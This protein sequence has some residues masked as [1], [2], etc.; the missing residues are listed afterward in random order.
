MSLAYPKCTVNKYNR[1]VGTWWA[2]YDSAQLFAGNTSDGAEDYTIYLK[3]DL[4][5]YTPYTLNSLILHLY[6]YNDGQSVGKTWSVAIGSALNG[7][8]VTLVS[9]TTTTF[10]FSSYNAWKDI[11]LNAAQV[12]ALKAGNTYI[13]IW[14]ANGMYGG[15]RPKEYSSA[16]YAPYITVDYSTFPSLTPPTGLTCGN[17]VYPITTSAPSWGTSTDANGIVANNAI[18]YEVSWS[19]DNGVNWSTYT[20]AAG[21]LTYTINWIAGMLTKQYFYSTQCIVKVNGYLVYNSNTYRSSA[22][23]LT[24]TVDQRIVPTAPATPTITDNEVYEGQVVSP[25][26]T[27]LRPSD[28]NQYMTPDAPYNGASM[29]LDYYIELADG[30][31]LAHGAQDNT[32][33]SKQLDYT[34]GNLTVG[35]TDRVTTIDAYVIDGAGQR[36]AK[37]ASAAFTIKRFRVPSIIINS[38]VR[39][40]TNGVITMT[41]ADTGYGASDQT[42]GMISSY[43]YKRDIVD[44]AAGSWT[45]FTPG[46]TWPVRTLT[47]ND[48]DDETRYTLT[49]KIY[50]QITAGM[51][52]KVSLDYINTILEYTPSAFIFRHPGATGDQAPY[53]M[54]GQA[55]IIGND[56]GKAVNKGCLDVQYDVTVGRDLAVVGTGT[57]NGNTI[58]HAGNDGAGSGSDADKLD[59]QEGSYYKRDNVSATDKL[60]GRSS[61][62]AGAIEEIP[63]T[64]AARS[65]LDDA[66]V[67]AMR[68]T[69]GVPLGTVL[70]SAQMSTDHLNLT[71]GT[72]TLMEVDTELFDVGS[73]FNTSTHLFTAPATGYYFIRW[74]TEFEN[75]VADKRYVAAIALNGSTASFYGYAIDHSG[76]TTSFQ[77]QGSGIFSL[78]SGDTIGLWCK[79]DA[80]VNTVDVGGSKNTC[81]QIA[82]LF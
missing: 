12:A 54:A 8:D 55:M 68:T 72:Y 21:V 78:T 82:R 5:A 62:G 66:T 53:G 51:A 47:F 70:V 52:A 30:T 41:V 75:V 79:N 33:A 3:F 16:A 65:I 19:K 45:Q 15:I 17:A 50:N 18:Q 34:T 60:L 28:Y 48:L 58:W 44:G 76:I 63:C 80:G 25:Q 56:F 74:S 81:L 4:S 26:F 20:V 23:Q 36:G 31:T 77:V 42:V 40:A 35:I 11:T 9:G 1:N 71:S 43:W 67:S 73:N 6:R 29:S 38:I 14:G 37:S 22:V 27:I 24:R 7:G 39:D 49:I 69:L 57:I 61:A 10:T 32:I 64:A 59:G 46:G 13:H 2:P